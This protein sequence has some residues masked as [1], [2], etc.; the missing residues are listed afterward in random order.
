MTSTRFLVSNYLKNGNLLNVAEKVVGRPFRLLVPIL[1]IS[2]LEYFFMDSGATAWLQYLPSVTWSTWPFT[3]VPDNFGHYISEILELAYLIPNAAPQITFNYCTGVLWTIPVQLQGSWV[4]LLAVIVIRE[5]KRPWKRFGF[6][7]FC[8]LM[9]WYALS[10]GT[11]F[12]LAILLT[13]LDIT[14]KYRKWL[15]AHKFVYY[16]LIMLCAFLGFGGLS[17][18]MVSQWTQVNYATYEYGIHPDIPTGLPIML[19]GGAGYP[20]YYVPKAH[21][22]VFS[23]GFQALVELSPLVQ[24]FFSFKFLIYV[25]PH[26]FT[27]YLIHGFI[28]WSIGSTLC[29]YLAG[30][31]IPYWLNILTVAICCYATLIASLPLLTPIVETLGKH[32]TANIWQFASEKPAPRRPTLFPFPDDFLFVRR[33]AEQ[34][35]EQKGRQLSEDMVTRKQRSSFRRFMASVATSVDPHFTNQQSQPGDLASTCAI[36]RSESG[37]GRPTTPRNVGW[38]TGPLSGNVEVLRR[39]NSSAKDNKSTRSNNSAEHAPRQ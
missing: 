31:G 13:D 22:I 30:R 4:T 12:Y 29:V 15:S 10:W 25:F 33:F 11:Y 7:S 38:R 19:T 32:I 3:T 9:H 18:D 17:L 8:I 24:K 6:Y 27:I 35:D 20:Q 21:G 14:F 5:V 36:S 1:A 37:G 28:F 34:E 2:M 26:I 23:L 16:P 39:N